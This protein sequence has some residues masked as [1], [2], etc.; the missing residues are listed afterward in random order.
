MLDDF[1]LGDV[2]RSLW[3]PALPHLSAALT[4]ADDPFLTAVEST[5]R[6]VGLC[7]STPVGDL[8]AGLNEGCDAVRAGISAVGGPEAAARLRRLSALEQ[9]AMTRIATGYSAGL[10][11]TI[12]RLR[13]AALE[14][15]PLD[16]DT[17][18]I[19]PEQLREKLSLEVNRCQRMD[20]SLGLVE[21]DVLGEATGKTPQDRAVDCEAR[22]RIGVALRDNLRRYDSVGL[23]D[24]DA[25]LLVLP[26]IS[27][28]GLAGAA[29]RLRREL[30][31]CAGQAPAL[32]IVFALA[33][34][35]Y[36]D[37]SAAEML[38]GLRHGLRHARSTRVSPAWS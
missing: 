19:K 5:A 2:G 7:Q 28:R 16:D 37:A 15:S 27:R 38:T 20:L 25:F 11:E 22:R 18:A 24:D 34:Y 1:P 33:H 26:G 29:E 32:G 10:E 12:S 14:A 21:L 8:L 3:E 23:T 6:N 35:D 31:E 17:G 9:V 30:G 36:V 13:S 4:G